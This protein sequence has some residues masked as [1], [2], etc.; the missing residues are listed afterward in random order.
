MLIENIIAA[1]AELSDGS[2]L[3]LSDGSMLMFQWS[4]EVSD[5]L[6]GSDPDVTT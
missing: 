4:Y 1:V 6:C 3:E 2:W 5:T